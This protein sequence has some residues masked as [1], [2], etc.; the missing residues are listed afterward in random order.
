[1]NNYTNITYNLT[2]GG[3][4]FP[5]GNGVLNYQNMACQVVVT[6]Y[7]G[8]T[9]SVTIQESNNGIDWNDITDNAASP[10]TITITANDTYMLKTSV[11]YAQFIRA[12]F[13][14]GNA[15]AGFLNI[16]TYFKDKN[17]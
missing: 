5:I 13:D 2:G 12:S 14:V 11:F 7:V 9:A 8:S 17:T 15:T 3:S 6:D 10:L 16:I 4:E 1:M